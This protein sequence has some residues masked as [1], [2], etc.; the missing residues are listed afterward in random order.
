VLRNPAI[1]GIRVYRPVQPDGSVAEVPE[2]ETAGNWTPILD[3]DT[4]ER[5]NAVLDA[6]KANRTTRGGSAKRVYPFSGL[7]RCATCGT[8][9]RK[10][11]RVYMCGPVRK[12]MC[13]RAILATEVTGFIEQAVLAVFA[14]ISLGPTN[15]AATDDGQAASALADVIEA[16]KAALGRLDDDYY[17]GLIDKPTWVRQR[18][19]LTDRIN[20]RQREWQAALPPTVV[21]SP[22]DVATVASQWAGRCMAWQHDA[23]ALVLEAVLIHA[24]PAGTATV[25]GRRTSDT[26][27]SYAMKRTAWRTA[28]LGQRIEFIWRA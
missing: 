14:R 12:G 19:R 28:V 18:N 25:P 5:L 1:K 6:R 21:A 15:P 13:A 17:D 10:Q 26:P 11:G 20:A 24:H 22:A 23:A 7:I 9:M 4:W 8:P 2:I 16:D 27:E 3:P